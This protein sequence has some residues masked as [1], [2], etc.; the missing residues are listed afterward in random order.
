[1]EEGEHRFGKFKD[2]EINLIMKLI[3]KY[4]N[5]I[6]NKKTDAV[7]WKQKQVTWEQITKEFN[8][9]N[10]TTR[11]SKNIKCKYENLKKSAKK[12][13][14]V[15]KRNVYKTG[16]GTDQPVNITHTDEK[17][18]Q[19]IGI[20]VEGLVNNYD[21]DSVIL[22][23]FDEQKENATQPEFNNWSE[24]SP[25]QLELPKSTPLLLEQNCSEENL[26]PISDDK[27]DNISTIID[28]KKTFKVRSE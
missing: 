14:A 27:S 3:S 7:M 25:A 22:E 17:I 8:A 4:K 9:I 6:E 11:S 26:Q 18:K 1:M 28:S 23:V 20:S 5:I 21:G 15:E 16:G 13:F 12:K 10:G 2:S 24:W 19:I